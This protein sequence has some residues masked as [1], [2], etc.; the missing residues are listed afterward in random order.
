[1]CGARDAYPT[2]KMIVK[3][4]HFTEVEVTGSDCSEDEIFSS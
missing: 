4:T 2:A 1:M 3:W